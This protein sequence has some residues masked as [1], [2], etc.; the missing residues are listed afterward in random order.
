MDDTEIDQTE[1]RLYEQNGSR[2][3][4]TFDERMKQVGQTGPLMNGENR[5]RSDG[6]LDECI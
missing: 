1:P 6:T 4:R 5:S 2:S 3:D